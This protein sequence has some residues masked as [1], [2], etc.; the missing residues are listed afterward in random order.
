MSAS[1]ELAAV[2]ARASRI[3]RQVAAGRSLAGLPPEAGNDAAMRGAVSDFVYGT[4]FPFARARL[5][6]FLEASGAQP[7]VG[8]QIAALRREHAR[9][10]ESGAIGQ[11]LTAAGCCVV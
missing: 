4:L 8:T 1:P 9:D 6:D 11:S 5:H 10:S 3:V 7:D 2:L